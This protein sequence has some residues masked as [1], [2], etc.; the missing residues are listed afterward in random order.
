MRGQFHGK[1]P[2]LPDAP[3][4]FLGPCAEMEM[5][6]AE[7]RPGIDDADYWLAAKVRF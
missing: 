7:F 4:H 3:L 2:G 1:A 6:G 5:A